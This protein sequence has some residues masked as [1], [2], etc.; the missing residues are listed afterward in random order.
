MTEQN[1]LDEQI[2]RALALIEMERIYPGAHSYKLVGIEAAKQQLK[3]LFTKHSK[4]LDRLAREIFVPVKGAE[5]FYEVSNTGKVRSVAGGRR[6]GKELAQSIRSSKT[7]YYTV[8][9]CKKGKTMSANV[10]RLVASAFLS[11]PEN[12]KCVNHIDGNKQNNDVSNLEWATYQENERHSFDVLGK[13]PH[14]KGEY[15]EI[16]KWGHPLS[17][18]NLMISKAGQRKCRACGR[19]FTNE[20]RA[21][22]KRNK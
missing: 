12:K 2:D 11:N 17:G 20:Y 21:Q 7:G 16:C 22:L 15:K 19:K 18:D 13:Q 8:S 3:T 6:S 5:G 10:H 14:N 1:T 4:E 9:F